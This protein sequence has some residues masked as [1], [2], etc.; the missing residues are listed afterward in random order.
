MR[1]LPERAKGDP[2]V[3]AQIKSELA[4]DPTALRELFLFEALP[5]EHLESLAARGKLV[6][7]GPGLLV[8]E[9]EPARYFFVLVEGELSLSKRTGA[10]DVE[11][12][13][14]SHRGA[15]CGATASFI[16]NPPHAYAFSVR[17]TKPTRMVRLDGEH[18]GGFIRT[19]YP[20]AVHL[21][22]GLLVDH[23]GVHQIIDQQLRI[24]A[25]GTL[26]AGL[27]HGLNNPAG[28]IARIAAQLRARHQSDTHDRAYRHLSATS[29][30]A[31]H[32]FTAEVESALPTAK[33]PAISALQHIHREEE[34]DEWLTG[35]GIERSWEIAP[36][37]AAAG[38]SPTW[39][40]GVA[41]RLEL[42]D[43]AD[44]LEI[45]VS[46]VSERVDTLLLLNELATAS[47]EVSAIV[48]AAQEYSQLDV[49]PLTQRDVNDLL[50]STLTVMSAAIEDSIVVRREY[51]GN[52]P[53]LLCYA[54]ELNQAWTNII[55]NAVDA[56]RATDAASGTISVYTSLVDH[57]LIRIEIRD[58]GT[59]IEAGILDRVFLP[60]FTT[61]PVGHGIGM[62]LDLAWR[63]IVGLHHGSLSVT[64]CPGDTR[65]IV[66]L[67]TNG[68]QTAR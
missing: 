38:L 12:I 27:M 43:A 41:E 47:A 18:L 64:S 49:S 48:A 9:G 52:L 46:A 5:A 20:M 26:T 17:A 15:Y 60:F 31:Y 16:E 59:G 53:P 22:Q 58:T 37:L 8:A 57:D 39:L 56:I 1:E 3:A 68:G 65:F 66:C 51:A 23:E 25:A 29:T 42:A 13:R 44:D 33:A 62:G 11:T 6:D 63:T 40:Q 7:Y 32:E 45:V 24:Q 36:I 35:Q 34:V 54:S 19:Q 30:A 2:V 67:P 14:T 50:D 4:L 28:A 61:K 21:L 10:R 55:V